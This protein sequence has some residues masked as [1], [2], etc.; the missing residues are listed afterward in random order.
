VGS[1]PSA[2]VMQLCGP[3]GSLFAN[4]TDAELL[5]WYRRATVAV[6]PLLTGAG[7]KLKSVEALWHGVPVVLTP[8]GAQGLP[9]VDQ[10]AGVETEPMA[11]AA[12]VCELLTDRELHQRRS[13]AQRV[14]A[15]ERF[16]ELAQTK[17]L[18]NALALIGLAANPATPSPGQ[19]ASPTE[20]CVPNLAMA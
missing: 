15:R 1:N 5:A 8:A 7:V 10:V 18:L 12:A 9:G 13:A 11:F 14:Y 6:V 3:Q 20:G 19:V 2:R 17:S 16:S 4:V